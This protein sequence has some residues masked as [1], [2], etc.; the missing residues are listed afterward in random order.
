MSA[1]KLTC[2]VTGANRG[3]GL[4]FARA[5]TARG[6]TVYGTARKPAE[7]TALAATGATV[8]ELDGGSDDSIA[9]LPDRIERDVAIDLLINNAGMGTWDPIESAT[10]A[11][12]MEMM[13]INAVAPVLVIKALLGNLRKAGSPKVVSI[14]SFLGSMA[15]NTGSWPGHANIS[16]SRQLGY[17]AS[18]AALNSFIRTLTFDY[19]D[20]TFLLLHPGFV[21]TDITGGAG[22]LDA[23]DSVRRMLA[24]V[25]RADRAQSGCFL[26][27]DGAPVPWGRDL[28]S[29]AAATTIMSAAKLTCLVTGAN[30]GIGLEF[31]RALTARGYTVYGTARKPAEATALA[32]TGATVVE[33]DGGSDGSIA[34][35]PDRIG[36][37]VAIDLL[38]NNAGIGT[39]DSVMAVTPDELM[40]LL[41][42]NA[43]VPVLVVK[44]LIDNLRKAGNPKVVN[45]TSRLGST[46]LNAGGRPGYRASKAA[47]N[48]FTKTMTYEFPD[49][50]FLLLHPG[51]TKT[52]M[53]GGLGDISADETVRRMLRIVDK[54]D[55]SLTGKF[56]D[57]DNNPLPW[58]APTCVITGANR[59]IG[60]EFAR[61]LTARG[62]TVY[63]TAR[64]PAE[65]TALAA[66]GATVVELDGGSDDSIATL[67]DRIG[68]DL[69]GGSDDSIA[70]LPDRIGRDVAIDLLINNAGVGNRTPAA[71]IS[72]PQLMHVLRTNTV[73]PVLVV[74]ALLGNLRKAGNPKVVNITSRMGSIELSTGTAPGYRASKAALN[75]LTKSMA[76]EFPDVTF[77]LLHPGYTKTDMTGGLG[78]LDADDSVRRMLAVVDRTDRTQSGRFFDYDGTPLPW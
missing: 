32:A 75:S 29:K 27:Y 49:V 25:D 42:T 70:T 51:Y 65:A 20:M 2:L 34:T 71:Q 62:Y 37:D 54:A 59:G 13:R 12:L 40:R 61:A 11:D 63:G 9:T 52:D 15:L 16:R 48:S 17:S 74:Q 72:G 78:D 58:A 43:V 68:R 46:E 66:T 10:S 19:P 4:E 57:Y 7:A 35:L 8:V 39:W 21:R 24:V 69:D 76:I 18:K 36:R 26:D 5:L 77:L 1:A 60:L 41:R 3:I 73:A 14:S 64:K 22:D 38:I 31:A 23:D 55:K 44:A 47:L 50:T 67:P 6:Y 56:F 45:I 28:I 53:T 33:L 30:R